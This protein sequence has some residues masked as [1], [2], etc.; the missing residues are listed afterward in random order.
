MR[1]SYSPTLRMLTEIPPDARSLLRPIYAGLPGLHGCLDAALDGGMGIARADDALNPT[2]AHIHLE[3]HLLAGDPHNPAAEEIV[4]N[5]IP[6]ATAI[7]ASPAWEPL[8]RGAW[9]SA[10]HT[11]TR[12]AFRAGS[13]ERV[14]LASAATL[15][16]GFLMKRINARDVERFAELNKAYV[17]N[18]PSLEDYINNGVGYGVEHA[19]RFVSGC[20]SF[21]I[22]PRS[23]EFEIETHP[24]FRRRGLALAAAARMIEHCLDGG[25]EPCWDAHNEMSAGLA[26]KLGFVDPSPYTAYEIRV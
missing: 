1:G 21:A 4:R 19:G 17:Y 26:L 22:S 16:D 8:I 12:T 20:S 10:L 25:L 13:W 6:P 7:L 11:R 5:L 23:L 3:F 9:G 2:V 15:P 14:H 24:D 18:F